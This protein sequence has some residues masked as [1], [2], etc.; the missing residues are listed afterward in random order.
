MRKNLIPSVFILFLLLAGCSKVN[1]TAIRYSNQ[2][3]ASRSGDVIAYVYFDEYENEEENQHGEVTRIAYR[4][5]GS[6]EP[7]TIPYRTK[8][9]KP[10]QDCVDISDDGT[11]IVFTEGEPGTFPGDT[12]LHKYYPD[13]GGSESSGGIFLH[14]TDLG[15]TQTLYQPAIPKKTSTYV[16][17]RI[18]GDGRSVLAFDNPWYFPES[19]D[20]QTNPSVRLINVKTSNILWS[21]EPTAADDAFVVDG[22]ISDDGKS[23][24][25]LSVK[26]RE[27]FLRGQGGTLSL[28]DTSSGKQTVLADNVVMIIPEPRPTSYFAREP[29]R[30]LFDFDADTQTVL[31]CVGNNEWAAAIKKNWETGAETPMGSYQRNPFFVSMLGSSSAL[32]GNVAKRGAYVDAEHNENWSIV[33]LAS[34]EMGEGQ[35][36]I[37]L[38]ATFPMDVFG[39]SI[40]KTGLDNLFLVKPD[41]GHAT[42]IRLYATDD[43]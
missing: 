9:D 34:D 7:V 16:W 18:S 4:V 5:A 30:R 23:C 11:K 12:L 25:L 8:N 32:I 10:S 6:T 37:E 41:I 36:P 3:V 28:L 33:N 27:G 1:P 21:Y 14:D 42:I 31:Y 22:L 15:I 17:G 40:K 26:T 43:E 13:N 38:S 24:L 35:Y 29:I 39:V 19:V 2:A 20:K